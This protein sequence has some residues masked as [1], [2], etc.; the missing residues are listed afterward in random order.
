MSELSIHFDWIS[1][2]A[3]Q[4]PE[5]RATWARLEMRAGGQAITQVEDQSARSIRES[6]YLPVYPLAEWIATNWWSLLYEVGSEARVSV[7]G[8]L[9]RHEMT[10]ASEGFALPRV[11]LLPEGGR[12]L[13]A[14]EQADLP[15]RRTRFLSR[16]RV[17]VQRDQLEHSLRRFVQAVVDRLSDR[18][19]TDTLLQEEWRAISTM[20]AEEMRFARVAGRLGCDP[21]SLS[22]DEAETIIAGTSGLTPLVADEFLTTV[23]LAS[24]PTRASALRAAMAQAG[25]VDT[26]LAQ[27]VELRRKGTRVSA[28]QTPWE[29]GYA[30]AKE[31]RLRLGLNGD[32]VTSV[33][34]LGEA[35]GVDDGEWQLAV[36]SASPEL[37][38]E[39]IVA[40]TGRGG[41]SFV[42]RQRPES[43]RT[44]G[45]C[46]AVLEYLVSPGEPA[47][48]VTATHSERQKRNRAFAAELLAPA[49]LLRERIAAAVVTEDDIQGMADQLGVS[50][51]VVR[52]QI[53][54]HSLARIE[55]W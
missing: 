3:A 44:F 50:S 11:C 35:L 25:S 26:G 32:A 42:L 40:V 43:A 22:D 28:D 24:L 17:Y 9:Q 21:Y 48:I 19:V 30:S 13:V 37:P 31:L 12:V 16:G 7:A 23:D 1:P 51:Y 4:G 38:V 49:D 33:T 14:W 15:Q 6:I 41:P 18:G 39:A 53:E 45:L 2:E 29:Q 46:R 52:H 47:A 10:A 27:M 8:Y 20:A 54:N 34:H 36:G 55:T 5:L